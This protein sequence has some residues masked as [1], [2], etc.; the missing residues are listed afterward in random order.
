MNHLPGSAGGAKKWGDSKMYNLSPG[1]QT[2]YDYEVTHS[3]FAFH[4]PTFDIE[5]KNSKALIINKLCLVNWMSEEINQE[6][7]IKV[8]ITLSTLANKCSVTL[9]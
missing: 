3:S 1:S 8:F 4:Q 7:S 9:N 6:F 2:W 5:R